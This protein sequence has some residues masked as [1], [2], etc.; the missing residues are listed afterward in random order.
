MNEVKQITA[1]EYQ[2]VLGFARDGANVTPQVA[3]VLLALAGAW[4]DVPR[5]WCR[6]WG[7]C[8][9]NHTDEN[10][11][12]TIAARNGLPVDVEVCQTC[13]NMDFTPAGFPPCPECGGSGENVVV[14][15]KDNRGKTVFGPCPACSGKGR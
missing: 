12:A 6:L 9:S 11:K 13:G 3:R 1:E 15:A 14:W 7:A 5:D 10:N 2:R 4:E 8:E